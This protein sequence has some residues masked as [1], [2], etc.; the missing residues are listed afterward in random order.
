[1]PERDAVQ[2][3]EHGDQIGPNCPEH[4]TKQRKH[5]QHGNTQRLLVNLLQCNGGFFR[6]FSTFCALFHQILPT[7]QRTT[8]GDT[9]RRYA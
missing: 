4:D 1:M 5:Q 6:R 2:I 8:P 3:A 7:R 9:P